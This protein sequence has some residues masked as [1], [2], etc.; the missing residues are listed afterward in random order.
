M[1]GG[2][3]TEVGCEE[4]ELFMYVSCR[5]FWAVKDG[6]L[7]SIE[8]GLVLGFAICDEGS[9]TNRRTPVFS[10]EDR[11]RDDIHF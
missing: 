10:D 9:I 4:P 6:R 8:G 7:T 3:E 11:S 2:G 5:R 1:V